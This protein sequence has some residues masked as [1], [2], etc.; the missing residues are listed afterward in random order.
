MYSEKL[1]LTPKDIL[2]KDFNQSANGYD[3]VEVD[4]YL[5]MAIRDYSELLNVITVKEKEI[6]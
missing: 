3:P 4:K 6:R 1:F 5:D 2:E